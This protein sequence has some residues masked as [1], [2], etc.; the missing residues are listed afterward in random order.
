MFFFVEG[1]HDVTTH[2]RFGDDPLRGSWV[3]AGSKFIAF[4]IDFAGRPKLQH[5]HY[6]V[7]LWL[8]DDNTWTQTLPHVH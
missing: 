6:R 4:P 3:V 1:T 2:A 8:C 5:S 7:S